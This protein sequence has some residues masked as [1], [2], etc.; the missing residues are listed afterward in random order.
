MS[1]VDRF[2]LRFGPYGAPR[3]QVGA[4]AHCLLHGEVTVARISDGHIPWPMATRRGGASFVLCGDLVQAVRRE[5]ACAVAH[6]FGVSTWMVRAWRRALGVPV[7]NEGDR[8]LMREYA[9]G[10][11]GRRARSA[12]LATARDPI[13]RAKISAAQ[14]G[15]RR[16]LHVI[17]ALRKAMTGRARSSLACGTGATNTSQ[18]SEVA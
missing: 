3:C 5:A 13:R 17:E 6:W 1:A 11:R 18:A 14:R 9:L 7:R 12:A 16:P 2:Q 15:R 8:L 10:D 4:A